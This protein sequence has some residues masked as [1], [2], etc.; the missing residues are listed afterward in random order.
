MIE[1]ASELLE[2]FIQIET[3]A[4]DEIDMRHMPTLGS[5]YEEITKQGIDQGFA[6]PKGLDLKVVS[7]FISVGEEMLPQQIDG[8]L[9]C[10]EGKQYGRTQEYIYS[11]DQVLCIFEV[12]KTL[13]KADYIDAFDHL[14]VIRKKYAEFFESK[15]DEDPTFEPNVDAARKHF[16]QITGKDA[17]EKY[18]QINNLSK[19]D[20]ILFYSL[21]QETLAPLS[22]IQGYG[23]YT[24]ES[25]MRNAFLD[26]LSEKG[27]ESGEGLGIPS[28][29]SLV[30]TNGFSI[31]KGNGVPFIGI[32]EDHEWAALLSTKG[33]A[34][35]IILEVIWSKI[36]LYFDVAMPWG[37]DSDTETAVPLLL[38]KPLETEDS[39]GWCYSPI[40]LK[41]SD[42]SARESQQEWQP[43]EISKDIK[44]VIHSMMVFGGY[45]DL[46]SIDE[47]ASS[48][49][50]KLD[51]LLKR[52]MN[53]LLFKQVGDYFR[54]ISSLL[55]MV[56]DSEDHDFISSSRERLD[57]WCER[58][59]IE[60][61][62][63]NLII[64][65]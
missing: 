62:Y 27:E 8:M 64:M 7:G 39:A 22:I 16:S 46:D 17:P 14:R 65:E 49:E 40:R 26:I 44:S 3:Q 53:T 31:V 11:I 29:P 1:K 5:A 6:I 55:H 18:S 9:V 47:I 38:A 45:V 28:L 54:P 32:N 60:K 24:T 41:E 35:R 21:V 13:N 52:L 34:A 19:S 2:Q 15:F 23:G 48:H 50:V 10:G 51:D 43:V 58:R 12:K 63:V 37:E 30:T 36:S 56:T 42:L 33:N 59:G 61:S 20:G 25:G 4:L 57:N